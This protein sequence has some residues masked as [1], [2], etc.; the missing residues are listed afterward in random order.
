MKTPIIAIIEDSTIVTEIVSHIL[1]TEL[2][3]R[4]ICFDS[5]E[6]AIRELDVYNPALILLD[7]NLDS[8]AT[9]NMNGLR[10]MKKMQLAEKSIP[11]IMM[12]GQT[13][14][15]VTTELLKTGVVSYLA[16]DNEAFLDE[17]L[18]E[19]KRVLD[20]MSLNQKQKKQRKDIKS[21]R[22]RIAT[23]LLVPIIIALTCLYCQC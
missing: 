11:V 7:Y 22:I 23:L 19:V 16:K 12:S 10:F 5:G 14:K 9:N 6:V 21:Q 20:A 8:V 18:T 4:T 13:D 3:V 1:E 17:L 15:R 2:N